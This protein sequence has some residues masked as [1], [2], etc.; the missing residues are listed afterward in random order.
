MIDPHAQ[1]GE[2]SEASDSEER[3]S[4]TPRT[5]AAA[6]LT[7]LGQDLAML[8]PGDLDALD[9]PERLREKLEVR[10]GLKLRARGRPCRLVGRRYGPLEAYCCIGNVLAG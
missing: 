9:L 7:R 2:K 1:R 5:R 8:A 6:A 3:C 10:Q 4:R